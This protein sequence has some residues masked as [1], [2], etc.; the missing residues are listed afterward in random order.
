MDQD[1]TTPSD[2]TDD[3]QPPVSQQLV[4]NFIDPD[5]LLHADVLELMG[6]Q[7]L[8]DEQKQEH[9]Q[10][11]METINNRLA[12][13]IADNLSDEETHEWQTLAGQNEQQAVDYLKNKGINLDQWMIEETI[14]YKS[15]MVQGARAI[16]QGLTPQPSSQS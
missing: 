7:N 2:S 10:R 12:A 3:I 6:Y 1:Q 9:Y 14:L 15:E 11:M 16:R 8:T 5:E 4:D 13:R